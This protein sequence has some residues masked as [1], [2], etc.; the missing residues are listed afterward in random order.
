MMDWG[1]FRRPGGW[2]ARYPCAWYRLGRE[3][4]FIFEFSLSAWWAG[5]G[6]GCRAG[7]SVVGELVV[8][9]LLGTFLL[10]L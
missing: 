2:R 6:G 5:V 1:F 4:R 3:Q 8:H 9:L 10:F 7:C